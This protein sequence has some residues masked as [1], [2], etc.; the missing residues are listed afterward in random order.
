[1]R[2]LVHATNEGTMAYNDGICFF[3]FDRVF[4]SL[5]QEHSRFNA[6]GFAAA[7]RRDAYG[8]NTR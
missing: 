6:A 1:M 7:R 5:R 4:R 2:F 3:F 8:L